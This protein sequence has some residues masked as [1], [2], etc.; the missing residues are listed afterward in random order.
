MVQR[1][2]GNIPEAQKL[3]DNVLESGRTVVKKGKTVPWRREEEGFQNLTTIVAGPRF[4][5]E[6][7]AP[8]GI[9]WGRVL[10]FP[11]GRNAKLDPTHQFWHTD[12]PGVVSS[13]GL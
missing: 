5:E 11:D 13:S 3:V 6:V 12:L 4:S 1:H 10:L 9:F 8:T 2:Q 7:R